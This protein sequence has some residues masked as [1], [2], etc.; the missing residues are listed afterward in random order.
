VSELDDIRERDEKYNR[1]RGRN[2][3]DIAE[4]RL[5]WRNVATEQA[6]RIEEL[7]E[8]IEQYKFLLEQAKTNAYNKG[9][10]CRHYAEKADELEAEVSQYK[11]LLDQAKKERAE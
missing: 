5:E 2:I 7:T 6:Q 1:G 3:V 4:S 11:W 8:E 9:E 10:E